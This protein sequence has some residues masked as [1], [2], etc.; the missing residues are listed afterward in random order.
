MPGAGDRPQHS[1]VRDHPADEDT[2]RQ[3]TPQ[4]MTLPKTKSETM[5]STR[6]Q[7]PTEQ[8]HLRQTKERA[9]KTHC[10]PASPLVSIHFEILSFF[11]K[12]FYS[13]RL[14]LHNFLQ[15]G[16]ETA[17]CRHQA[18]YPGLQRL[19]SAGHGWAD[20]EGPSGAV[21]P[22]TSFLLFMCWEARSSPIMVVP[23]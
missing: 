4:S 13:G 11:A 14:C 9:T 6:L 2:R 12:H 10:L 23:S 5:E 15:F 21:H 1:L 18:G 7:T 20:W 22:P 19:A 16:A 17:N 8:R 3:A